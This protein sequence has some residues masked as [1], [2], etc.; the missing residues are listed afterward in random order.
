MEN[1]V[2]YVRK[3]PETFLEKNWN[4]VDCLVLCQ[5]VY[6]KFEDILPVTEL[7]GS[8]RRNRER[9]TLKCLDNHPDKEKLFRDER[10]AV[11]NKALWEAVTAS[12]RFSKLEVD[13]VV[14]RSDIDEETQFCA[15]TFFLPDGRMFI[16]FRGT[17]ESIIGWKEDFNLAFSQTV[18]AQENSVTYL[19]KVAKRTK[20][21]I[22]VGGH[23]K[24]GNLAIYSAMNCRPS[25]Q[26]RVEQIYC[27]DGPGFRAKTLELCHYDRIADRVKKILPHSSLVGML[28]ETSRDFEVIESR[29]IGLM[30]HDPMTWVV[31]NGAFVKSKKIAASALRL[32][33]TI[34]EW[35]E[36]LDEEHTKLFVN[37]I[38][39]I[40]QA[41][42]SENLIELGV[43]RIKHMQMVLNAVT[44]LDEE[45]KEA[46]KSVL[47]T[48]FELSKEHMKI[49]SRRKKT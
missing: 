35:L 46:V 43:D 30:Q 49:N 21:P 32:D 14:A 9:S 41:T 10:Y 5:L 28:F 36:S 7:E 38:F 23:S 4:E 13:Y 40:L 37:T 42:E 18:P 48:F 11:T 12:P 15:A 2:S 26:K 34:N 19:N 45:T 22:L 47:R 20:N 3:T 27:M 44:Q 17:D 6:L 25:V 31:R 39:E 33:D 1:M 8:F 29:A 24:G 16:A